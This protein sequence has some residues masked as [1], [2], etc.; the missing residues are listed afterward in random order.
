[1]KLF[2]KRLILPLLLVAAVSPMAWGQTTA[3]AEK[4]WYVGVQAGTSFGQGT[5]RSITKHDTNWG[6]QGG[7][8]EGYRFSR[9]LSLEGGFQLGKQDQQSQDCCPFWLSQDGVRYYS[10]VLDQTGWF[11]KDVKTS[12]RWEKVYL[13][14][15]LNLLGLLTKKGCR[16]TVQVSPQLSVMTTATKYVAEGQ[17]IAHATRWHLGLGGQASIGFRICNSI[18]ASVYGGITRLTGKRFDNIPVHAHKSNHILDAGVKIGL[19]L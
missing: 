16:W 2:K 10:P 13:Q 19:C 18:E 15:N 8:Y 5:F 17:K 1:M 14:A 12:T 4:P 9:V 7:V 6:F 3:R 11:Y